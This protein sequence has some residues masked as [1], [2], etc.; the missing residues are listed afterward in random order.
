MRN[1]SALDANRM[2]GALMVKLFGSEGDASCGA[3]AIRSAGDGAELRVIAA[4]GMGWDRV[5]LGRADRC[6]DWA[7]TDQ[8]KRMLFRDGEAAMQMHV[9]VA[10][11]ISHHPRCLHLW[12]P[13]DLD[14]LLPPSLMVAPWPSR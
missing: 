13:L 4:S 3:F 7:E 1:L 9:P 8:L 12:R 14:I 10:D 11:H 2:R 5:S 6:P